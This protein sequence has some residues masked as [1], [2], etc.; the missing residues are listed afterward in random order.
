MESSAQAEA[1]AP[2]QKVEGEAQK[3]VTENPAML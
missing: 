2:E 3:E 1:T